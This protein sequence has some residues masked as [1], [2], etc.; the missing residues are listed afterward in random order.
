MYSNEAPPPHCR[1]RRP[2]KSNASMKPWRRRFHC[3]LVIARREVKRL[4]AIA[5]ERAA[6]AEKRHGAATFR[7]LT[8]SEIASNLS[9]SPGARF[10]P[11]SKPET[12]TI[13]GT[14]LLAQ[15]AASAGQHDLHPLFPR[16]AD[17]ATLFLTIPRQTP[18]AASSV[19]LRPAAQLCACKGCC[20]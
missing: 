14:E 17:S 18:Y 19:L 2:R 6:E 9:R 20:L 16:Q 1:R 5:S 13:V 12:E 11:L 4:A 7:P 8:E 10:R 15:V 3:Q